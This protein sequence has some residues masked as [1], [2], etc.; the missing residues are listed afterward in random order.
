MTRQHLNLHEGDLVVLARALGTD[1]RAPARRARA[2]ALV[3]QRRAAPGGGRRLG[4]ARHRGRDCRRVA[5]AVLRCSHPPR[6][7]RAV[8]DRLGQRVGRAR[9]ADCPSSTSSRCSSSPMRRRG[10]CSPRSCWPASPNPRLLRYR[11][12]A[13]TSTSSSTGSARSSR[14]TTS[15]CCASSATW[16]C[17]GRGCFPTASVRSRCRPTQAEHLGRS[18]RMTDDE[19][20]HLVDHGSPTPGLDALETLSSAWYRAAAESSPDGAGP[21]PRCR[22]P[23]PRS[24]GGS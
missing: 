3:R 11:S 9:V 24:R 6:R 1:C 18:V 19:L 16:R 2:S 14:S 20:N 17:S 23:H 7:R 10:C 22:L 21:A 5:T 12:T 4:P 8:V 13:S 15:R